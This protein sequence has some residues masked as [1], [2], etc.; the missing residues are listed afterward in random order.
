MQL[1]NNLKSWSVSLFG[2]PENVLNQQHT[3]HDEEGQS[4]KPAE[5]STSISQV[6][7]ESADASFAWNSWGETE[8]PVEVAWGAHA[9]ALVSSFEVVHEVNNVLVYNVLVIREVLVFSEAVSK[10]AVSGFTSTSEVNS[11]VS[12]WV[13]A[14]Q[15]SCL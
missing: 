4:K 14:F 11:T 10:G 8:G 7:L 3:N 15:I 6:I 13:K 2:D 12:V 9:G 5:S 1:S